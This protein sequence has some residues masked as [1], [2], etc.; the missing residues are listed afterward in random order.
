ME[1]KKDAQTKHLNI[2]THTRNRTNRSD[3]SD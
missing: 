2:H 3:K 1:Q